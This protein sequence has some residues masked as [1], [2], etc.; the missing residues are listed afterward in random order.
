MKQPIN[1]FAF[2]A[3]T[4]T[5]LSLSVAGTAFADTYNSTQP[6]M[7][8]ANTMDKAEE[9]VSDTWITSK[10]KSAFLADDGLSALDIK[11]ETNKGVVALSGVV[12]TEAERD[13]AVAKAKEIKGVQAVSADGLKAAD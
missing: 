10:V 4:A 6:T 13:L 5:A 2:A 7:L 3:I 8:A 9:A 1:K 12:K 11:V